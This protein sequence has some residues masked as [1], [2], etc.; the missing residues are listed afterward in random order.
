MLDIF[1]LDG[2]MGRGNFSL[3]SRPKGCFTGSWSSTF[4]SERRRLGCIEIFK[5]SSPPDIKS[6]DWV[7]RYLK[8]IHAVIVLPALNSGRG[9]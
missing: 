4:F 3:A 2:G 8:I 7:F 6:G 5:D 1:L 9:A